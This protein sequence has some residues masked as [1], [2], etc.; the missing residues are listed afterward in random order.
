METI[1]SSIL[2]PVGAEC[3][4]GCLTLG[5]KVLNKVLMFFSNKTMI[6]DSTT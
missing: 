2:N 3:W 6:H 5:P 1:T 4:N